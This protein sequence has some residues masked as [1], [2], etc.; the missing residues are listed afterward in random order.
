M[1]F[2]IKYLK[3]AEEK[4]KTLKKMEERQKMRR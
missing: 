1:S 2:G 3:G 4:R